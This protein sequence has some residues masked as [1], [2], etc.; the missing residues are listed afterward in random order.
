M[1]NQLISS[2]DAELAKKNRQKSIYQRL[3]ILFFIGML[4]FTILSR[5]IDTYRVAQVNTTYPAQGSITKTVEGAGVVEAGETTGIHLIKGLSVGKIEAGPGAQVKQGDP[6]F[7]YDGFSM[8]QRQR[9]LLKDIR[10]LELLNEQERLGAVS[11][12]GMTETELALQALASVNRDLDVQKGKTVQAILL[13]DENLL[14]LKNYYEERLKLS[15]EELVNQSRSDF[16]QSQNEYDTAQLDQDKELRDIKRKIKDTQKKLDKLLGEKAG[17]N[18]DAD[19]G[20]DEENREDEISDLEDLLAQYEEDLDLVSEKW[21]LTLTHAEDN[22]NDKEDIYARAKREINSAKLALQENHENAVRQ[23]EMNLEAALDAEAKALHASNEAAQSVENAK[24]DDSAARLNK[25]K[26]LR[27]SELRC[28]S[29]QMDLEGKKEEFR[30]IE[31]LISLG[32]IV[33]A[34]GDGTVAMVEIEQGKEILGSERFLLTSGVLIFK[35]T[36][37]RSEDGGI[38]AHDEVE[39][40]LRG[41]QKGFKIQVEQVDLVT[42][43]DQ[44]FFT[45]ELTSGIASLGEKA[46]FTSTERTDLYHTVIPLNSLRKDMKGDFCLVVREQNGILGQE[47]RA[48]RVDLTLLYSGDTSA[49]VEGSLMSGDRV[50][51]GSDRIVNAGDRVRLMADIGGGV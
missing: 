48:V 26:T 9:A 20:T 16:Y 29:G 27:L 51:S 2:E 22:I 10:K 11:Y 43:E 21:D 4:I 6:L 49:A 34:P 47:Y 37:D 25:E 36:F 7:Y 13:H 3:L 15:E 18:S 31:E 14:R 44:G 40:K 12:E 33:T 45:G 5:I 17:V 35:G 38:S 32:G 30:A 8:T 23:E 19:A 39:I 50:I 41:E 42:S 24:R 46:A 1:E 28:Q